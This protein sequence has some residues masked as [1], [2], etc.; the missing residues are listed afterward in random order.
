MGHGMMTSGSGMMM[1]L[2]I[3]PLMIFRSCITSRTLNYGSHGIFLVMGNAGLISSA[4]VRE[5]SAL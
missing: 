4:V 5:C 1:R 2:I 3:V